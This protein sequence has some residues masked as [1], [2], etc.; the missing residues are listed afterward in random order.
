MVAA[1]VRRGTAALSGTGRHWSGTSANVDVFDAKAD[2]EAALAAIGAPV[3]KLQVSTDAPDTF[4]P[5]RSG[6]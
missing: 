3:D 6:C 4:H 2:A 5:G 1:G